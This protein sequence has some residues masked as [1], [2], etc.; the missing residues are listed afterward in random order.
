MS[1]GVCQTLTENWNMSFTAALHPP[2][3]TFLNPTE[4]VTNNTVIVPHPPYSSDYS[5]PSD[6]ALFTKLKMELK[7]RHFLNSDWHPKRVASG[8]QQL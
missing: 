7:G 2:A 3:Q 1:Y 4:F 8:T 5:A 6:F